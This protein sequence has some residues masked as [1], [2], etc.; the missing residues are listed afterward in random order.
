MSPAADTPVRLVLPSTIALDK[1]IWIMR[2]LETDRT[3]TGTI[4]IPR[5]ARLQV[6]LGLSPALPGQP[7]TPA[8]FRVVA[9]GTQGRSATVLERR[10]DP[11]ATP[12]DAGWVRVEADLDAARDAVGP[13]AHFTFEAEAE[14]AGP[15]PTFPVWGD[16]TLTWPRAQKDVAA[17]R[18][19]V[20]LVSIDTLRADRLGAYGAHRDT[21]PRL[22]ALATES[23]LFET[24][25]APAPWTLPSHASMMTGLYGCAHG[26][27][28]LGLGK[29]FP[30]GVVPL[31]EH[32]RDAG[33]TTAAFTEDGF[34][35]PVSFAR[36]APAPTGRT[37]TAT[38]GRRRPWRTRRRGS[39]TRRPSP[40]SSS[41]IPTSPT[42]RTSRP[43][44]T[45]GCSLRPMALRIRRAQ[46][47]TAR[48]C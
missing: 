38:T 48:S 18:R 19:N 37:A 41:P 12:T 23:T 24:V 1:A 17:V 31:A 36:A 22:D 27:V 42:I 4:P 39:A 15:V 20:V 34:V 46:C 14:D 30:D 6:A 25:V 32:L 3:E 35:D 40:S 43:P 8:R 9:H 44:N 33:Y 45:S 16:P 2:G 21:S 28:G 5:G 13:E 10:L 47:R 7:A 26:I 11:G 29:A